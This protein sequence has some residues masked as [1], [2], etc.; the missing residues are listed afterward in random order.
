MLTGKAE[1]FK[2]KPCSPEVDKT[3]TIVLP[4]PH[5]EG[6]TLKL[7]LEKFEEGNLMEE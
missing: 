7:L 1:S 2:I 4:N 6:T 3:L 5:R